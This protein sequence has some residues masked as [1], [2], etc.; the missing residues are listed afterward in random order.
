MEK[1]VKMLNF[2]NI[3]K[4]KTVLITGHTGFKGSWLSI[5]LH[6]LGA[7]VIGFALDPYT[8][9]DNFV[10]SQLSNKIVDIRGDIRDQKKIN[11]IFETYKPEFVFHLAAQPLVRYSYDN[12]VETYEINVMGSIY[13]MEAFKNCSA[14]KYAIMI[15]TD[16]CY[17]NK[18]QIWG[19]KETDAMGGFD[20]YSSSKGANEIAIQ[21]YRNSFFNP[22]QYHIHKKAI[23]SAR[24]GNV[25]GGG[26]WAKDRIVPDFYRAIEAN[27][28]LE[29]R[30]PKA[31]RPWQHVLEPLSGYLLLGQKLAE[32][33]TEYSEGWN[34]GPNF[35]MTNT[36]WD[37]IHQLKENIAKGEI[38][39]VSSKNQ[40]HEAQ[41]L[42]LDITK[43]MTK[44]QWKPTLDIHQTLKFTNEW[45]MNY[46]K[47]EVYKICLNQINQFSSYS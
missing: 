21:S 36:V 47:E 12:P 1:L 18:E 2:N 5:W 15:T 45:Y 41:L 32:N 43:A 34:F 9:K 11:E 6:E 40:L 37:I 27:V 16:K 8:E 42:A 24:A 30:N 14:S 4:D 7:K 44:L 26:D 25:I 3:Y 10:L 29:I 17:K 33:P 23:A 38:I 35:E 19:Y 13:V 28:P 31:T 20:P 46:D 22:N 39:D